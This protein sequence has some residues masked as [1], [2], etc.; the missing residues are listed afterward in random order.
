[1]P[2]PP[3][4]HDVEP[5]RNLGSITL[6]VRRGDRIEWQGPV[7]VWRAKFPGS[8]GENDLRDLELGVVLKP[9]PGWTFT[10]KASGWTG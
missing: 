2:K 3:R 9:K 4:T 8:I 1:M 6:T 5:T 10:L 7:D